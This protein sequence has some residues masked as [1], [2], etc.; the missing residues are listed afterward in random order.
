MKIL[1]STMLIAERLLRRQEMKRMSRDDLER[2]SLRRSHLC[3]RRQRTSA[4]LLR[5]V[6]GESRPQII[7]T[8]QSRWPRGRELRTLCLSSLLR[9][10][11]LRA[12]HH[13]NLRQ[14]GMRLLLST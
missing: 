2:V 10:G 9:R 6:L 12:L 14:R 1:Q 7:W 4:S 13:N 3:L 5:S 11:K 8:M